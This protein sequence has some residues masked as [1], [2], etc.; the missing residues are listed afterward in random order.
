MLYPVYVFMG[1][2]ATAFGMEFPDFPGC[3]SAVDDWRG[4]PRMAPSVAWTGKTPPS[5]PPRRSPG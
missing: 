3:F 4:I 5:P 2:D 1:D